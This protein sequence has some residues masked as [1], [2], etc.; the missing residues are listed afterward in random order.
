MLYMIPDDA[1]PFS[2]YLGRVVTVST[3]SQE[4]S[5]YISMK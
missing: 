3:E 1:P 5:G 4:I 2:K